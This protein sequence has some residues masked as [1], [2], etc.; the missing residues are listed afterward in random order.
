MQSH[1]ILNAGKGVRFILVPTI[2]GF[3]PSYGSGVLYMA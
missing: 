1:R 3:D 2:G